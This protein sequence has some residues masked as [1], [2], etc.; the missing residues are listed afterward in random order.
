[1][2]AGDSY[3]EEV[4]EILVR[5]RHC[6]GPLYTFAVVALPHGQKGL[7]DGIVFA[8]SAAMKHAA[9]C[10]RQEVAWSVARGCRYS[11]HNSI[12][13]AHGTIAAAKR[14]LLST[15]AFMPRPGSDLRAGLFRSRNGFHFC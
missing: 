12:A 4:S 3:L 11:R 10:F 14:L 5:L 8:D 6:E 2:P 13:C 15:E 9:L 7:S 1:M